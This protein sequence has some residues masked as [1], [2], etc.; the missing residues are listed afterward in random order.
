MICF[1][2]H[3]SHYTLLFRFFQKLSSILLDATNLPSA[4]TQWA[5]PTKRSIL[6]VEQLVSLEK[7]DP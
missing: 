2:T 7:K 5:L 4:D 3:S 6:L 1:P